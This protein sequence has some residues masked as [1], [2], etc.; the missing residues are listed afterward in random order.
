LFF[1]GFKEFLDK[2][3]I[4]VQE[5]IMNNQK[6]IECCRELNQPFKFLEDKYIL[7]LYVLSSSGNKISM[8]LINKEDSP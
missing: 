4:L 8:K 5:S 1:W 6:I 3:Y 2:L 7:N